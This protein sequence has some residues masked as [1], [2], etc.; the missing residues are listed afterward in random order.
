MTTAGGEFE[1]GIESFEGWPGSDLVLRAGGAMD[2]YVLKG[3]A[4]GEGRKTEGPEDGED[5]ALF[6]SECGN[7]R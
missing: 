3:D 1:G 2:F 6:G 7:G 4:G 5:V